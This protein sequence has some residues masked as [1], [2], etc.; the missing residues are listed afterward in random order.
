MKSQSVT[1]LRSQAILAHYWLESQFLVQNRDYYYE[2]GSGDPI[3]LVFSDPR[4]LQQ[5]TE[6]WIG[7]RL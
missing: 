3:A 2:L 6:Y 5:F 4:Y 7:E 1:L